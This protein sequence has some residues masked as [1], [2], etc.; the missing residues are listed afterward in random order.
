M[1]RVESIVLLLLS[2]A[3]AG[4]VLI[5]AVVWMTHVGKFSM[6]LLLAS[7]AAACVALAALTA[8]GRIPVIF[9]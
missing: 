2:S 7:V 5:A 1:D 9:P 4:G 8:A 6:R 3:V